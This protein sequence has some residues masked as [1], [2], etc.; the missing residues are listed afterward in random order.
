MEFNKWLDEYINDEK[1]ANFYGRWNKELLREAAREE[2]REEGYEEAT[3]QRNY[4]IAKN[5]LNLNTDVNTISKA[6]GLSI[7]DIKNIK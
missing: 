4:D 2:A 1:T 7:N 5:L 6:T 3:N